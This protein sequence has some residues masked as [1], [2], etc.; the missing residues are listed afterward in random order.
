MVLQKNHWHSYN[1]WYS[2]STHR[3]QKRR[4]QTT[5][6]IHFTGRT[7]SALEIHSVNGLCLTA[8]RKY[9]PPL[10]VVAPVWIDSQED[11]S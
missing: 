11:Q 1:K 4:N 7:I 5:T 3:W 2:Y 8:V 9:G 10:Q 6:Q